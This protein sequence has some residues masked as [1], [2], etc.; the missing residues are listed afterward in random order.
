M[1][2]KKPEEMAKQRGVFVEGCR[3][4]NIDERLA[5]NIFDLV[6]KFAGYGFNKSHSVAYAVLSYQTAWLKAHYPAEFYSA[7][8]TADMGVTDKVVL[9]VEDLY[10]Y[11]CK[12][13]P[14]D[15]NYSET[16]F[17][18]VEKHVVRY[19]LA[20]I[21]GVGESVIDKIL[22]ERDRNGRFS[23]LLDLCQRVDG[24]NVSRSV[25]EGLIRAG[26]LDSLAP[27]SDTETK[28]WQG[29][30]TL[31]ANVGLA[32]N[33][34][35]QQSRDKQS[36]QS[37]LF[38]EM[39][40]APELEIEL[41]ET[42][43]WTEIERL[44]AERKTTG[45]Y[46]S[47]HPIEPYLA[48][49]SHMTSGRIADQCERVPGGGAKDGRVSRATVDAVMAGLITDVRIRATNR[50]SKIMTAT[51]DDCTGK[52]DIVVMGD[53]LE[54]KG[55]KL[56][57][58]T[59]VV[60]EGGLGVDAFSGGFSL[61]AKNIHTIDEARE[62]FARLLLVTWRG[63]GSESPACTLADIQTTLASHRKGGRLPVAIDYT[64][65]QASARIRL[66]EDWQINPS[67]QLLERLN[68]TQGVCDVDLVY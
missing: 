31:A 18:P 27:V 66:G 26:A 67:A 32:I 53:L 14:P 3:G 17:T 52:V 12:L 60:V 46:L 20:A 25:L 16:G 23:S 39:S 47:G 36:G 22:E 59:L 34:A 7:V 38:G 11:D 4:N 28:V 68:S 65:D 49:L 50:G 54:A 51:M 57:Q 6:E 15:I 61:R 13:L 29:R 42:A 5:S 40:D 30:S 21:K 55:M 43:P 1:G 64:N 19:G 35:N 24:A 2:K 8:L 45:L 63:E 9:T 44:S 41:V 56:G 37:D 33:A 62:R 10:L 58:D 48:E